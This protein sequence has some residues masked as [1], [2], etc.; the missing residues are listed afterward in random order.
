[1]IFTPT[2]C[3][4]TIV[5]LCVTT[6]AILLP[7]GTDAATLS[8]G[9]KRDIKTLAETAKRA[10]DGDTVEVDAGEYRR[11]VAVW[12]QNDLTIRAVGGRARMVASGGSAEGK[13]IF[14][15]RGG[16][17]TIEGF[18]FEGTRV[19]SRNG[20]GIRFEAGQLTV[21]DCRFVENEMGLLTG[22]DPKAELTVETSEFAHN[23]RL[24]GHNH[25]LYAGGIRKL[26]VRGSYLHQG[27]IGHLLKSRAA[28]NH[29][30]YNRFTDEL[31]GTA[32]YEV[33]FPNGGVA[34]LVG[35]VVQQSSTS[36]NG[37]MVSF[38]AEGYTWPRHALVLSHNTLVDNRPE[39][40]VFVRVMQGEGKYTAPVTIKA[41]NNLLVGN[42]GKL[43]AAGP[44]EYHNNFN[45]DWDS[46]VRASR[47]DYRLVSGAAVAGKAVDAG[48]FEGRS[49][50]PTHEYVHPRST[51]P[52][53]GGA[54]HPGALQTGPQR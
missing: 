18:D 16:R 10:Q 30:F 38:G 26:T 44:G 20:A 27:H 29:L 39:Q 6:A 11:D 49:L 23:K 50:R 22:N 19:P 37:I 3:A 2:S 8:V 7:A 21:R 46:F 41:V 28:V 12:T 25:Q 54:R 9:P 43:E 48:E 14:V 52:L 32:S 47:E 31:G 5:W 53:D 45:V 24:D 17:I 35:N 34:V 42:P 13:A 33:E 36:E 4:G 40:G 15:V 51:A 1:M